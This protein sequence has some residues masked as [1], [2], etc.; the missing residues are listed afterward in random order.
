MQTVFL[1]YSLNY[2]TINTLLKSIPLL[3]V[4]HTSA[5]FFNVIFIGTDGMCSVRQVENYTFFTP[6][7]GVRGVMKVL[8]GTRRI[9]TYQYIYL[10]ITLLQ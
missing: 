9:P 1:G 7:L 4:R 10:F 5:F 8:V 3:H 6:C 2:F